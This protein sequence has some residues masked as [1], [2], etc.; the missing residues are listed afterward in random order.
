MRVSTAEFIKHYGAL[1]DRALAEPVTITKNGRDR[2]VVLS[3][4]EFA[5]LKS[6][7]RQAARAE[8]LSPAEIELIAA[9]EMPEG[10][11][12]LDSELKGWAP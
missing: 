10:H 3:A 7:D 8:D 1:A 9:A 11:T 6:R 12:A 5:R 2:L 4:E